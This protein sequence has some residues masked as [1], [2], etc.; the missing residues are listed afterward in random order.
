MNPLHESDRNAPQGEQ[1]SALCDGSLDP[2]ELDA[3]LARCH[4]DDEVQARWHG[5]QLIGE[6]L[7][8]QTGV[9]PSRAPSEFLQRLHA[10]LA[11]D[12]QA[13]AAPVPSRPA[14]AVR[15]EAANDALFRWKLASGFASVVAVAAIGWN[16]LSTN[17]PV[18]AGGTQLVQSS[19]AV[20]PVATGGPTGAAVAPT[21]EVRPVVVATPQGRVIR[22]AELERLLA[23]HRQHG[24]MSAFQTSTGFIRNATYDADAR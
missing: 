19:P 22:D 7:R 9:L 23:A 18:G 2:Q 13:P 24:S 10:G 15:G 20:V 16:V 3:L 1:V 5:Y 11:A 21:P 8:G 12:A 14:V 4:A 6:V 17:V